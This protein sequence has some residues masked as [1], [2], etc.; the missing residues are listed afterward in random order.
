MPNSA[1]IVSAENFT[2]DFVKVRVT[3][4]VHATSDLARVRAVA[5]D[6]GRELA[7]RAGVHDR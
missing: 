2:R 6:V 4:P 5:D 3:V 7:E 1:V